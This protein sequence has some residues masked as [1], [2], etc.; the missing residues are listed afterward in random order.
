M[1][2]VGIA[3]LVFSMLIGSLSLVQA[4]D[5]ILETL[6][7]DLEIRLALSANPAHLQDRATVYAL[8]PKV[9]YELA[10]Q[11]DNGF[12]CLVVR[13]HPRTPF[14]RNDLIVPICHDKA[15]TE[16]ILPKWFDMAA[17]RAKGVAKQEILDTIKQ[18]F[19]SGKYKAPQRS[20]VAP[21]LSSIFRIFPKPGATEPVMLNYPHLMFY[22]PGMKKGDIAGRP[23]DPVY[24]WILGEGP[25]ALIIQPIG[26]TE[27]AK[28]NQ[29]HQ[30]LMADTCAY[31]PEWCKKSRNSRD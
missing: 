14:Y 4:D 18:N 12:T 5:R 16:A 17:L 7:R 13:T 26:A 19:A 31:K 11:G 10:K 28:L 25:H 27:R 22:A 1:K 2:H 15:G 24:P 21:M 3:G 8:N 29:E 9:G 30:T 20:G 6:P 23:F